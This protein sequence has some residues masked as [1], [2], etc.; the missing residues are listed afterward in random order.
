MNKSDPN[1]VY[2]C[3]IDRVEDLNKRIS[4]RN[5]PDN[6]LK[7]NFSIRPQSTKMSIFPIIDFKT[8]PTTYLHYYKNNTP[9]ETFNPGNTSGQYSAYAKNINQESILQNRIYAN[10][11]CEQAEYVPSSNSDMYVNRLD[12]NMEDRT[13]PFP[14]LFEKPQIPIRDE[15]TIDYLNKPIHNFTRNQ[16]ISQC[17]KN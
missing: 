9:G 16:R 10:Q 17:N 5:I 2:Y 11:K 8:K 14:G 6:S 4:S 15:N 12:K 13:Q 3:N 1:F 7:P